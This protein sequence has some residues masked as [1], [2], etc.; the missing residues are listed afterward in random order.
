MSLDPRDWSEMRTLG[1]RMVGDMFDY[2]QTV[3][4]RAPWRPVPVDTKSR[5]AEPVPRAPTPLEAVYESFRRDILPYPTGNI[6]PRFWGW[7]MG[8]GTPTGMLAEMLASGM[9][10]H[11]AGYDQAASL[12]EK[13]VLAWCS[14]LMGFPQSSSALLVSGGTA[15]NLNA[16]LAARAGKAGFDIREA[17]IAAGPPMTIYAST[18]TH[19]WIQ[20][21]VETMGMGRRAVH[22]I[23][24]DAAYRIDIPACRRAIKADLAAGQ[25]PIAIVGN[26]GTVNTGA[27]D[28][29]LGLRA[30]ADEF[31]L[32]F[33]VDGAFGALA[34]LSNEPELVRGQ[35]TADSLAFDLHKWGYMPYDVGVVLTRAP[36]A[37]TA[38]FGPQKSNGAPAY[39]GSAQAGIATQATYFA[40]RGLELSRGF[41]ALKVWMSFK[42]QG[43]DAIG[44]AI[45][46]NI[47]QAR[48]LGTLVDAA[49][50]LERLAPVSLNIVCFRFSR[51]GLTPENL[52]RLNQAILVQLQVRGIAVPSQTILGGAF[53]IRVCITNHRS[54]RADFDALV[55]AVAALGHEL[56]AQGIP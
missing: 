27:V 51:P 38:A 20:R 44:A 9:N 6:H 33:H 28:D 12:I 22:Q 7:V 25:H 37:Q 42:E 46:E 55:E 50:D 18:Q 5:I 15:A 41:R 36:E 39:L 24:V 23:E 53:A 54:E 31:N 11:V 29:L 52:N 49:P 47:A 43:S 26:A 56:A 48:Y 32:W 14:E 17:G 2:L 30:L 8:T 10:A 3:R 35:E 13:Q 45:S 34:A 4:E 40:D 16:L 21:A 19:S 1:V